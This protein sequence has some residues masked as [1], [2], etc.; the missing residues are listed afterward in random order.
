MRK[1]NL[2]EIQ[3]TKPTVVRDLLLEG[4]IVAIDYR[5]LIIPAIVAKLSG[6]NELDDLPSMVASALKAP[7]VNTLAESD[8]YAWRSGNDGVVYGYLV[9]QSEYWRQRLGL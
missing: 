3:T 7:L 2:R 6:M 5:A 4:E 1:F 9:R 8:V